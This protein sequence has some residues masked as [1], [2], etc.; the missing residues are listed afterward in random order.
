MCRSGNLPAEAGKIAS[1]LGKSAQRVRTLKRSSP[2]TARAPKLTCSS[3]TPLPVQRS[4]ATTVQEAGVYRACDYYNMAISRGDEE[5]K[6]TAKKKL[7]A[8]SKQA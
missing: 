6:A 7:S 1:F 8:N 4:S 3:A 2:T 5:L